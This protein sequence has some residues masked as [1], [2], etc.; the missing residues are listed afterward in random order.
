[1][2]NPFGERIQEIRIDGARMRTNA[3]YKVAFLGDQAVPSGYG[4][5]R[6]STGVSAVDALRQYVTSRDVVASDT[7]GSVTLV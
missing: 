3:S 7:V 6:Q 2:E 1:L 4:A 5:D